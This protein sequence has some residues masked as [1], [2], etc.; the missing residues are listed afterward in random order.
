[1]EFGVGEALLLIHLHLF[2][3]GAFGALAG[4]IALL[5]ATPVGVGVL[6]ALG[7]ALGAFARLDA[8]LPDPGLGLPLGALGVM[9]DVPAP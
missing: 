2:D 7:A 1:M 4:G 9:L 3:T 6:G 5:G 8:E